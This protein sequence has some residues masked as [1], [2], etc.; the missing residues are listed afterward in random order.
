M[1]SFTVITLQA[2]RVLS[3]GERG[4]GREGLE[5]QQDRRTAT[6]TADLVLGSD[7]GGSD[8]VSIWFNQY[9]ATPLFNA[10]PDYTRR[11]P[12]A[13]ISMALDWLNI[14]SPLNRPDL[15]TGCKTATAGNFFVWYCQNTSG[16]EGYYPSTYSLAYKTADQRRRAGRAE[17]WTAPAARPPTGRTSSSAP[18]RRPPT[19]AASSCG[20][21]SNAATPDLLAHRDLPEHRRDGR[22]LARRGERHGRWATSTATACGTWSVGTR[23]PPAGRSAS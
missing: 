8:Q 13:V 9:D 6:A 4:H 18:S 20:R 12:G 5:R 23:A 1:A 17:R 22:R 21:N 19:T 16:N 15:V 11:A 7:T 10:S 14:D 3:L 2:N